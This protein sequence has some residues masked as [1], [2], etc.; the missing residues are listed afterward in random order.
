MMRLSRRRRRESRRN[1][2]LFIWEKEVFN[3]KGLTS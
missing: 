3:V 1:P 2:G